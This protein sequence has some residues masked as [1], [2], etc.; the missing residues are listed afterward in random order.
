MMGGVV[1][2]VD[3]LVALRRTS[4]LK[5]A[6]NAPTPPVGRDSVEPKLPLITFEDRKPKLRKASNLSRA[7]I[8]PLAASRLAN[9]LRGNQ[10]STESRPTTCR[11]VFYHIIVSTFQRFNPV[12]RARFT[13]H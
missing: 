4:N 2:F 5:A 10:G 9:A 13:I 7:S 8:F 1:G 6:S 3:G 11:A 12:P